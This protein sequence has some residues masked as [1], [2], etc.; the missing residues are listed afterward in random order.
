MSAEPIPVFITLG[1]NIDPDHHLP[2]AV[3]LLHDQVGV[4]RVS[5]VYRSLPLG[6]DGQPLDQP[7]F[8]NA[9][10]LVEIAPQVAPDLLKYRVLRPIETG[11]GRARGADKYAP[12]P[13]DLDIALYGDFI[14]DDPESGLAIPDPEIETRA[15]VA[16]PLADRPHAY[17]HPITG[18]TQA[19]IAAR[20]AAA[21]GVA[22]HPLRLAP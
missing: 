4:V 1:S 6:P 10:V 12:R 3:G 2:R 8:L 22:L 9:A 15:H 13:I 14:L 20:F 19:R 5:R 17:R 21:P 11:M 7:P 18:Q 16:L